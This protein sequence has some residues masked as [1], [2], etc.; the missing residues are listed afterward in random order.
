M[1]HKIGDAVK[2]YKHG[3]ILKNRILKNDIRPSWTREFH[4]NPKIVSVIIVLLGLRVPLMWNRLN[5]Q[6]RDGK[7]DEMIY[8]DIMIQDENGDLWLTNLEFLEEK[9]EQE[10]DLTSGESIGAA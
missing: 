9:D 2:I 1:E 7:E 10:K 8:L 3:L 5:Q 4:V 6:H